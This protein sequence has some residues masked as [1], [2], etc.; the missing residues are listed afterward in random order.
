MPD[1]TSQ[2]WA[3]RPAPAEYNAFYQGYVSSVPDGDLLPFLTDQLHR[4]QRLMAHAGSEMAD[5]QYAPGKWTV[6]EVLGH[7][8]D[9]EWVF[10]SRLLRM[11]RGDKAQ[12]PGMDQDTFM[13]HS[14]VGDRSISSLM[15]EFSGLRTAAMI[16]MDSLRPDVLSW[17]GTASGFPISVRAQ[18]WI[19]AGHCQ[20]HLNILQERYE[21][22]MPD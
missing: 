4:L 22:Q 8:V 17:T 21:L 20:H 12:L 14:H 3:V 18:G 5:F 2:P 9:T 11:A 16:L 6:R 10:G 15:A 7:M 13:A 19:L 1:P